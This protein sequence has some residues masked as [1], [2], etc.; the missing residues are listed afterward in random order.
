M[1]ITNFVPEI[2]AREILVNLRNQLVYGRLCN[3][4]YEGEIAQAGDTVHI[5]SFGKPTIST[6]TKYGTLTYEQLTDATR[7]LTIDQAKSF[8]FGVDDI[9][10]RQAL[11]G[12]VENAMSDAGFGLAEEA[13]TFLASTM[14]TAVNGTANDVGAITADTSDANAYGA[15]FVAMRTLLNRSKIPAS[16]RWV[17]VPPELYGSLLQDSKF[18]NAQAAADGGMALHEGALGRIAGFDVFESNNVPT[19]TVGVYSVIAGHPIAT[20]LADQ[21]LE[22][23]ALRLIDYIG[24]GLRGLHVYG[25]KVV[26]PEALALASVTIQA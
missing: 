13:D 15:V 6:Y 5:T 24:D 8:S 25:A 16:G 14:Y 4:N 22:T 26:R 21:I 7:A 19:E 10:R 9:D 17:V 12:F 18:I 1:A 23:E 11:G 2:W 20:T 3:R